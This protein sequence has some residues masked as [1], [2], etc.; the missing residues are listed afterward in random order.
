MTKNVLSMLI[1]TNQV[2]RLSGH[3]ALSCMWGPIALRLTA[4][5]KNNQS[6]DWGIAGSANI[7]CPSL[8]TLTYCRLP[9][10][11]AVNVVKVHSL[12]RELRF[13]PEMIKQQPY[14]SKLTLCV[15]WSRIG[16][17][18]W[19]CVC[20]LLVLPDDKRYGFACVVCR[21]LWDIMRMH[22]GCSINI[23]CS[24]SSHT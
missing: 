9:W 20:D 14:I 4:A 10:T 8:I 19:S 24:L 17:W 23:S 1:N 18:Q 12:S 5:F 16:R 21:L 2:R 11:V 15:T 6:N 13:D 3:L 22:T 7:Y